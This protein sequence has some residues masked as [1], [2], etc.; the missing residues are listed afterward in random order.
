MTTKY[1]PDL[2]QQYADQLY[3]RARWLALQYALKAFILGW[4][5]GAI[6]IALVQAVGHSKE[7]LGTVPVF[8]GLFAAL[9][10]VAYASGKAFELKL[11]AQRTLCQLQ[12]ERNTRP[13]PPV[14]D[15]PAT[16]SRVSLKG[17]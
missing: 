15:R 14:T 16:E 4:I 9:I 13:T 7:S 1:D 8:I 10:A 3:R 17:A 2:L 12:I 6:I 5:G 11:D